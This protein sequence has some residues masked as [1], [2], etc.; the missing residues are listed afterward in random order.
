MDTGEKGAWFMSIALMV[1]NVEI[2]NTMCFAF[3]W[4]TLFYEIFYTPL[5]KKCT[6]RIF[7]LPKKNNLDGNSWMTSKLMSFLQ[8]PSRTN[9]THL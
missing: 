6:Q 8:L 4:R 7:N 2:V 5:R 3:E 9:D 1:K